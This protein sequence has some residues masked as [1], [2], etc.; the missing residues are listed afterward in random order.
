LFAVS[1]KDH[2]MKLFSLFLNDYVGVKISLRLQCFKQQIKLMACTQHV[3]SKIATVTSDLLCFAGKHTREV[4]S[5][6]K[7]SHKHHNK[8]LICLGNSH[9]ACE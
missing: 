5:A 2:I 7:T 8:E 6:E 9:L 4:I 1:Y 3:I